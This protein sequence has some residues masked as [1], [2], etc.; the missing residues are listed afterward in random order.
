[1][2]MIIFGAGASYDSISYDDPAKANHPYRPPLTNQI[3]KL[4]GRPWENGIAS[5]L[6]PLVQR[7]EEIGDITNLEST[8]DNMHN[9]PPDKDAIIRQLTA[10]R[11]FLQSVFMSCSREYPSQVSGKTNYLSII[12]RVNDWRAATNNERVRIVTFNYDTMLEAACH[13]VFGTTF[14]VLNDYI[15][16]DNFR[17]YKPHGS[18][19]W[20][21]VVQ[22][23]LIE[24]TDNWN[25]IA[26][27]L[28]SIGD[29][30]LNVSDDFILTN[31]GKL[32]KDERVLLPAIA[33]PL[34]SKAYF[35]CPREHILS[36]SD[37]IPDVTKLIVI[38]WRATE[39]HF[40]NMWRKR[41]NKDLHG[42]IVNNDES[43]GIEAKGNLSDIG[44]ED[45]CVLNYGFSKFLKDDHLESFLET[46]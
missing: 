18:V 3:F 33:V 13:A 36:L 41:V 44:V 35:E 20:G 25:A 9:I 29:V 43:S 1:M 31:S 30:N 24:N 38:G 21:R 32:R 10:F 28:S 37:A 26:D 40:L 5:Q 27:E 42:I 34:Q 17:I 12:R 6:M 7:L 14:R 11:F 23:K 16:N 8:L 15:A 46:A 22:Y 4:K 2:L 19:N 45:M 39:R